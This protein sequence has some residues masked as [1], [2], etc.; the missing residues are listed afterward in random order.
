MKKLSRYYLKKVSNNL[1]KL[2]SIA[3]KQEVQ[4]GK[5]RYKEANEMCKFMAHKFE[6][7][8]TIVAWV[9]S[10]LSPRNKREKNLIDTITVFRA[11]EQGK[12]PDDVSVSTFHKNK[13]KA[14][15]I[16]QEKNKITEDSL[17]T[18][19]F[20]KNI[21]R[22]DNECIVIDVRHLRACFWKTIDSTPWKIAYKQ[23]EEITKKKAIDLWIKWYELQAI[24]WLTIKR[25]RK[26]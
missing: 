7:E 14:F 12:K 19:A 15:N 25:T 2:Y 20:V 6:T 13:Y 5:K 3:T 8:I 16:A 23:I 10:A 24:I 18:F 9:L 26:K 4:D 21:A 11:I 22:L 17:K 1:E